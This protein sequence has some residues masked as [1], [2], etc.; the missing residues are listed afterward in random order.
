[1]LQAVRW[2]AGGPLQVEIKAP[3]TVTMSLYAQPTGRRIL[4]LVNYDEANPVRDIEVTLQLPEAKSGATISLLS[5]DSESGMTLAAERN[6][7]A[8]RFTV[9]QLNLYSMLVIG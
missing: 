2:A 5:P 1:L 8:L 3:E 6:G 7:R 4:H 9:P